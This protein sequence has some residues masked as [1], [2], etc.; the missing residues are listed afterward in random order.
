MAYDKALEARV[1]AALLPQGEVAERRMMGGMCFMVR[2]H[3]SLR[4]LRRPADG[5]GRTGGL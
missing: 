5:E 3:M 1:R 2:G 4:R